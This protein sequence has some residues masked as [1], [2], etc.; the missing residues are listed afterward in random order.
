MPHTRQFFSFSPAMKFWVLTILCAVQL[1]GALAQDK[2]VEGIVFD[3]DSKERIAKVSVLNVRNSS[4]M[5][6]NLKAE[7]KIMA[8]VGDILIFSKT[9]YLNDTLKVGTDASIIVYLKRPSS[10]CLTLKKTIPKYMVL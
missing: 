9:G 10:A 7:F 3:K 4:T 5:Y 8:R 1:S 6:D 2:P